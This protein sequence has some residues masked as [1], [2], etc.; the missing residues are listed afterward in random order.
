MLVS[1]VTGGTEVIV[2]ALRT[3]PADTDDRLLAAGVAHST[4]MLDT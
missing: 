3:L 1:V 4:V 2:G